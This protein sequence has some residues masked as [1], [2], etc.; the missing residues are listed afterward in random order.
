MN[1]ESYNIWNIQDFA[2]VQKNVQIF[3]KNIQYDY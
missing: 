3:K 2:T 1:S